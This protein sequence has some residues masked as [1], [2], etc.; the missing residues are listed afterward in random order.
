MI[1]ND[2][3]QQQLSAPLSRLEF[4]AFDFETTGLYPQTHKIIE[5]GAVKFSLQKS[6][7]RFTTLINPQLPIP[8]EASKVNGI[9]DEMVEDKPLI[10]DVLP[11][12]INFIGSSVLIAHNAQ[13][14]MGFLA[15]SLR[16][17]NLHSVNNYIIDTVELAKQVLPGQYRYSLSSLSR[18]LKLATPSTHRAEAD[19][20]ACKELFLHCLNIISTNGDITLKELYT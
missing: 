20:L 19:A 14:D 15:Y 6:G 5:I 11:H 7:P 9:S 16:A 13:F 1:A 10:Q 2:I 17:C 3:L 18:S 4:I 12:F 8:D